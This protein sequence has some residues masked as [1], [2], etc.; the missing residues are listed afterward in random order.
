[1]NK[2]WQARMCFVS[3]QKSLNGIFIVY[4]RWLALIKPH[5]LIFCIFL[6]LCKHSYTRTHTT[7][8]NSR[9]ECTVCVLFL[10]CH[11]VELKLR[12]FSFIHIFIL[13]CSFAFSAPSCLLAA[14]NFYLAHRT[15]IDSRIICRITARRERRSVKSVVRSATATLRPS[16]DAWMS[17][18]TIL[19]AN[20][21]IKYL[22]F[23][24][25]F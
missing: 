20:D 1:M 17:I 24:L 19:Y 5:L 13:F 7:E 6:L 21:F 10:C 22:L 3:A 9:S 25:S 8:P 12:A 18:F 2:R 11:L 16:I 14:H 15:R 4:V 23:L